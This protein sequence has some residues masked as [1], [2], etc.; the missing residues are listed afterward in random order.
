[1]VLAQQS[2]PGQTV[3]VNGVDLY[4][5]KSGKGTPLLLLHGWTQTGA[6]WAPYV[7]H[8]QSEYEVYVIDL[9]GHGRSSPLRSDF[10]IQ[11][12]ARDIEA[13]IEKLQ[14]RSVKAIGLSY[15]GLVLL[16]VASSR[17]SLLEHMVV[18]GTSFRYNGKEAQKNKPA[19]SYESLD[20]AFKAS[21]KE[22]H[23]HGESQI[24]ALF[25]PKL[26]YQI[27][28]S[29]E[30]LKNLQTRVLLIQGDSDEIAGIQQA[31]D[32]HQ[33]MPHSALWIVPHTGHLV[34][35]EDNQEAFIRQTKT[36]LA[37]A[38]SAK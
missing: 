31:V 19:F 3:S 34:L 15:G 32:M 13:F 8:F 17:K 10:S 1:M 22:Q 7:K 16:E 14:L 18:I 33:L 25:D 38:K 6:F 30:Q 27:N 28:L 12:A 11:Q 36:F 5:E 26:D 4:Y 23:T 9:R 35:T 2:S 24:K 29:E 21:L 20:P 37:T